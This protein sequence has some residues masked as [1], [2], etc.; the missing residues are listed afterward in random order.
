MAAA[1]DYAI[2]LLL[3][4][5]ANQARSPA[6]EILFRREA[7]SRLGADSDLVIRSA[8]VYAAPGAP[9]LPTMA[10]ALER[11]GLADDDYRSRAVSV[12]ELEDSRLVVTMTEAHRREVN[13]LA[14]SVVARSYTLPE[15]DRLVSSAHWEAEWDGAGDAVD[16]LR[17]LRPLVAKPDRPEDVV[18]P[19]GHGLD[20]AVAVLDELTERIGRVSSHLFG[21]A[22]DVARP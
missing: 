22:R 5:T 18:D 17:G 9:L 10:T 2:D 12:A 3:V 7:Q 6:A 11:R 13:R 14:P 8:G 19:A 1:R 20:V 21:P 4:C 16:R 15:L